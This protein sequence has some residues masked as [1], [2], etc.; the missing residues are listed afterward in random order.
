[1]Y[2]KTET[3]KYIRKM[4]KIE[5]ISDLSVQKLAQECQPNGT[6]EMVGSLHIMLNGLKI[7]KMFHSLLP[8]C[9]KHIIKWIFVFFK[10]AFLLVYQINTSLMEKTVLTGKAPCPP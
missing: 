6:F 8:L 3:G 7:G 9:K 1:M 2:P 4:T 10:I 5:C